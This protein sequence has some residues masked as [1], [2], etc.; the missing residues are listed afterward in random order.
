VRSAMTS[1]LMSEV[2]SLRWEA[3]RPQT[4]PFTI[5][6][7]ARDLFA[8]AVVAVLFALMSVNLVG[9]FLRTGHVTGLLLVVSESLVVVLTLVRRHTPVIDRSIAA[10]TATVVSFVGPAL[11][12]SATLVPLAP[13]AITAVMSAAGVLVVIGAKI[14]LGRS[15]GIA[16]ANRGVVARGPYNFVRHPIY[17]GYIVTHAAFAMAHPS[18]WNVGVLVLADGALVARA[19]FEERFLKGDARYRDYCGRVG[20]H[21]VPGVF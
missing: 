18:A 11:V 4:S 9:D 1:G 12:R 2:R 16:P 8:R 17:A 5:D 21:L 6:S 7:G 10:A 13:D 3:V 19:L 14:T 20:W 15:F